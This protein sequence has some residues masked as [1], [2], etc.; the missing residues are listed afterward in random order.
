MKW[1]TFVCVCYSAIKQA[2]FL[3][4][5]TSNPSM[6]KGIAVSSGAGV[7]GTWGGGGGGGDVTQQQVMVPITEVELVG[8]HDYH[9]A[10]QSV[11]FSDRLRFVSLPPPLEIALK[12]APPR[13]CGAF[14]P[15]NHPYPLAYLRWDRVFSP[16]NRPQSSVWPSISVSMRLIRV[17]PWNRP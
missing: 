15:W 14:C 5:A 9:V 12:L 4:Y 8:A 13:S 2:Q 16:W 1:K 6:I 7:N 11:Y 10:S 3:V 17:S